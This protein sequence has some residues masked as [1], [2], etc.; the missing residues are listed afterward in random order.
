MP[1]C[2]F[3]GGEADQAEVTAPDKGATIQKT[4]NSPAS[5][6]NGLDS[7]VVAKERHQVHD[8]ALGGCGGIVGV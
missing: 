6:R 8:K 3:G 7:P 5:R 4:G 2:S 1:K